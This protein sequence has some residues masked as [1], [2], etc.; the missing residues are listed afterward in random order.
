MVTISMIVM[1]VDMSGSN[2][3]GV[4]AGGNYGN[5]RNLIVGDTDMILDTVCWESCEACPTVVEGCTDSTATNYNADATVDNGTCEY[6]VLEAANL[7]FSE[8]AEGS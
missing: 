2:L 4:C 8:Y 5:D 3:E 7:F 6:P 1:E